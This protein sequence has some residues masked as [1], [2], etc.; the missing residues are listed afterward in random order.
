MFYAFVATCIGYAVGFAVCEV[1]G[2]NE[3]PKFLPSRGELITVLFVIFCGGVG[4]CYG[5]N[6]LVNGKYLGFLN[7]Y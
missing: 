1:S 7:P 5:S 4:F 6:L 2:F 3:K